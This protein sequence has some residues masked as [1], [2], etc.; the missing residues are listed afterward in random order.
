MNNRLRNYLTFESLE[1]ER[2]SLLNR[3]TKRGRR[4]AGVRSLEEVEELQSQMVNDVE[5]QIRSRIS[6]MVQHGIPA[7]L[8]PLEH[9]AYCGGCHRQLTA[10]EAQRVRDGDVIVCDR[11][12]LLVYEEAE[13]VEEVS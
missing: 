11:C 9:D 4:P 5:P 3:P 8:V 2:N 1:L 6:L 13:K 12:D 7:V 10:S